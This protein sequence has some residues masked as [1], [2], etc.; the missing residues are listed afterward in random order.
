MKK[1][2]EGSSCPADGCRVKRDWCDSVLAVMAGS[3]KFGCFVPTARSGLSSPR[4]PNIRP[5][6]PIHRSI[7][8]RS[9]LSSML[10]M[11]PPKWSRSLRFDGSSSMMFVC[12][13][14][15]Q[16]IHTDKLTAVRQRITG[17]DD[18]TERGGSIIPPIGQHKKRVSGPLI[19]S[20]FESTACRYPT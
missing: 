18:K 20:I 1:P 11:G 8:H 10:P 15:E 6:S 9:G 3:G 4:H 2:P 5:I 19:S 13:A 14:V 17:H 12:I 16:S 7:H